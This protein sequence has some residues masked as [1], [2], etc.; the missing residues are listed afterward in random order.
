MDI[1]AYSCG[2]D[3]RLSPGLGDPDTTDPNFVFQE[4]HRSRCRGGGG[5][6]EALGCPITSS[7]L[8]HFSRGNHGSM[9]HSFFDVVRNESEGPIRMIV[10]GGSVP[11]GGDAKGCC[12][13]EP[14]SA[15]QGCALGKE[16]IDN[17]GA[18]RTAPKCAWASRL[19]LWLQ[20]MIGPRFSYHGFSKSATDTGWAAARVSTVTIDG[21]P[22]RLSPGDLVFL[23]S[24]HN[25]VAHDATASGHTDLDIITA[26]M[27][28]FVRAV[29][30]TAGDSTLPFSPAVVIIEHWPFLNRTASYTE[31]G[32]EVAEDDYSSAYRRVATH[33]SVGLWSLKD[34]GWKETTRSYL[35]ELLLYRRQG[36]TME[37][38]IGNHH[39]RWPLHLFLADII[40]ATIQRAAM[41][42]FTPERT[43]Y[44]HFYKI[45]LPLG[46]GGESSNSGRCDTNL[47][48]FD[49]EAEWET[50]SHT[51]SQPRVAAQCFQ[52]DDEGRGKPGWVSTYGE[53]RQSCSK[54]FTFRVNN[55]TLSA[56]DSLL[57]T[58]EYLRTYVDAGKAIVRVCNTSVLTLDA[59]WESPNNHVSLRSRSTVRLT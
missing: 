6:L 22:W 35:R 3:T 10:F 26:D 20:Q 59:L 49:A 47:G 51:H 41:H 57:L 1:P 18:P 50:L 56:N 39:P 8:V 28:R 34:V 23:D 7:N 32:A 48:A 37:R 45:P 58:A 30:E 38:G 31:P 27:Q 43:P 24:S 2:F 36:G 44:Q 25:D 14:A 9:L 29:L 42:Y 5:R 52:L 55:V 13:T 4:Q 15:S 16:C 54:N 40:G 53:E 46:T 12:C 33:Y 19:A 21:K 17:S 11:G